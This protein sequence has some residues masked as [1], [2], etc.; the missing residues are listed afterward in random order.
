[1]NKVLDKCIFSV[2]SNEVVPFAKYPQNTHI[3][4]V[5]R[6]DTHTHK[7]T[8]P[9]QNIVLTGD[10]GGFVQQPNMLYE[11]NYRETFSLV[12]ADA[13]GHARALEPAETL[14]A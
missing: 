5:K 4:T 12:F 10:Q 6:T 9:I 2:F 1:M 13:R 7:H 8:S 11:T 3:H 14:L